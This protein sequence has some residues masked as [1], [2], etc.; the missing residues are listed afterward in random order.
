MDSNRLIT[1]A[2]K[3]K[4]LALPDY[5]VNSDKVVAQYANKELPIGKKTRA[6]L[7]PYAGVWNAKLATHLIKRTMFGVKQSEIN[8][9]L[10][11]GSADAAVNAIVNAVP[12]AMPL[13]VNYYEATYPD[14]TL[15]VPLGAT[16]INAAEGDGTTNY[17]RNI[18]L[19]GQWVRAMMEQNMSIFEKLTLFWH[20]HIP[21]EANVVNDAR[22][23]YRYLNKLRGYT[24][25]NFKTL[26]K[27]M[28][29]EG[30]MLYY[31]NGYVN[32]KF[33]PDENYARELQELFTVGKDGGQQFNEDDV[34]AAAR[35]LTGWRIDYANISSYFEPTFHD[36]A[37]KVFSAF[38]GTATIN[39]QS[40]AAA[41]AAELDNLINMIF[42]GQ[43]GLTTA[44]YICRE[45]YK[46]FVYYN[47]DANVET[48][49]ITPLA[50]TFV[51]SNWEIKPVLLQ[52]FKSDHFFETL[53][54]GCLIKNAVDKM[55]GDSRMLGYT[56]PTTFGIEDENFAYIRMYFNASNNGFALLDPPNVSGW[57]MYY[58]SPQFHELCINSD[59]YPKRLAY[60]DQTLS[61]YGLYVSGANQLKVDFPEFAA[62]LSN[63]SDPDVLI[64]DCINLFLGLDLDAAVKQTLKNILLN[65]NTSNSYWT[66]AWNNYISAPTDVT[67]LSVIRN[68]MRNM[69]TEMLRLPESQL[70]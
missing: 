40:G 30:A 18:G 33:S 34:K 32:N 64:A 13:P 39:G 29:T 3:Q 36:T 60:S 65:N 19:K 38:Y 44:K 47:I 67:Y 43:S 41:G 21:V 58:Q 6:G 20:N 7:T 2:I 53:Q 9:L 35:A 37:N 56:D 46:F 63:P 1:N 69:L 25:G 52:L 17:Y 15:A 45:L 42:S 4:K 8:A 23:M 57:K 27:D 66:V 48:N 61:N 11:L 55:M 5:D 50:N 10:A 51:A 31:L 26:V 24:L 59:T 54:Q 49:I 70:A 22:Y 62:T 16:W 68:R 28:T 12:N 14:S